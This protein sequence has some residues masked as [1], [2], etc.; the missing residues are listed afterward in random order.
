MSF[1]SDFLTLIFGA[2]LVLV[3]FGDSHL[4]R[5]GGVAIGNLDTI[6]GYAL[7]PL[8]DVF[9]PLATISVFLLYG[10][11]KGNGFRVCWLTGFLFASFLLVL[12]LVSIDDI[13]IGLDWSVDLSRTFW[14]A[15]SWVYPIY[16]A[17]AFFLFGKLHAETKKPRQP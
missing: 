11:A 9:Y 14:E 7:W 6:L 2:L 13:A 16:S 8:L 17:G 12:A 3:T 5:I 4:G 15:I 1:K 10:W